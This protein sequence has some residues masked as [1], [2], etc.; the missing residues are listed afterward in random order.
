M[1]F[2]NNEK[3]GLRTLK[4]TD[5]YGDTLK[6]EVLGGRVYVSVNDAPC[7]SLSIKR[8]NKIARKVNNEIEDQ[9]EGAI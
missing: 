2:E 5:F 7:V 8:F 6:V 1:K 9:E 4:H 3:T